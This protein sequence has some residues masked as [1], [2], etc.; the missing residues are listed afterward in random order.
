MSD[1]NDAADVLN[2]VQFAARVA[3]EILSQSDD[4]RKLISLHKHYP[5]GW[6]AAEIGFY[7]MAGGTLAV[8]GIIAI[9]ALFVSA[10]T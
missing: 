6:Q 10:V 2:S 8:A 1:K 9:A 5:T 7:F 3:G 4:G